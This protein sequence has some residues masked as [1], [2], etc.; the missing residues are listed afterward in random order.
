MKVLRTLAR[1]KHHQLLAEYHTIRWLIWRS[2]QVV[3]TL[4]GLIPKLIINELWY[5][6]LTYHWCWTAPRQRRNNRKLSRVQ[7]YHDSLA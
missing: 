1:V 4:A 7:N 3:L 6:P 5:K 2:G